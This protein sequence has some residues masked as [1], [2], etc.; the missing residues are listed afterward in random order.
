MQ[1]SKEPPGQSEGDGEGDGVGEGEGVGEGPS[2]VE[3]M[4][5]YLMSE[6]VT[7]ESACLLSTSF[8]TPDV[9]AQ[10]PLSD[11][12]VVASFGYVESNQSMLASWSSQRDI[13][14]TTPASKAVSMLLSP[15]FSKKFVPSWVS[16]TQ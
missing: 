5:P 12:G 3:P 2:V 16:A 4:G 13:T 10:V 7:L 8:G 14:S 11:P 9:F 6:K 1:A 15:P